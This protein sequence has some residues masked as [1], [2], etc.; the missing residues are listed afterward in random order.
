MTPPIFVGLGVP[1]TITVRALMRAVEVVVFVNRQVKNH[2]V[3][4]LVAF[5]CSE[6]GLLILVCVE[7]KTLIVAVWFTPRHKQGWRFQWITTVG[8]FHISRSRGR[9]HD[10]DV[11]HHGF[12]PR[13]R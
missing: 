8:A 5:G 9:T 7:S 1:T 2:L 10:A 3:T 12:L 4:A 6:H 13:V 11:P